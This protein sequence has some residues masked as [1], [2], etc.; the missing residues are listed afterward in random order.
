M[1]NN[2]NIKIELV[3]QALMVVEL[4]RLT[5]SDM[6]YAAISGTFVF[7]YMSFHLRSAFVGLCSLLIIVLSFPLSQTIYVDILGSHYYIFIHQ[8][9][10][11]IVLGIGADNIFVFSDA[12]NQSRHVQ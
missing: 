5:L 9:V 8:V 7:L 10:V 12:W 3:S 4:Y 1:E 6:K 2:P 11:F